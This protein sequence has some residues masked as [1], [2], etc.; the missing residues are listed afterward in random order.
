M[1]NEPSI[2][3]TVA[4]EVAPPCVARGTRPPTRPPSCV[5]NK[6]AQPRAARD[7]RSRRWEAVRHQLAETLI[8]GYKASIPFSG[9][10]MT[11]YQPKT[12][13]ASPA[14][15]VDRV[16]TALFLQTTPRGAPGRGGSRAR[17]D[18]GG[19][20]GTRGGHR[21]DCGASR[22]C[23]KDL[24][25]PPRAREPRA[26]AMARFVVGRGLRVSGRPGDVPAPAR[27]PDGRIRPGRGHDTHRDRRV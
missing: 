19:P 14:R 11:R 2:G 15:F 25:A 16:A 10:R 17:R 22:R 8:L 3:S 21:C 26:R 23:R 7:Y 18:G 12:E 6:T 5:Q 24:V 4:G 13:K 20:G 1:W 9:D 27:G